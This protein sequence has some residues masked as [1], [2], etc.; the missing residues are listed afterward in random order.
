MAID[1]DRINLGTFTKREMCLNYKEYVES[2]IEG[3]DGDILL[4]AQFAES[5][6]A[7]S[8]GESEN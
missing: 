2:M 6:V 4:F 8:D 3:G 1:W 7:E 5:L